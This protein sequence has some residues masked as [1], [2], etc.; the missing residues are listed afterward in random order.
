[1]D[2]EI[3][4]WLLLVMGA[5]NDK[6]WQLIENCGDVRSAAE[7]MR[8][9]GC[10][11]L[12]KEESDRARQIRMREVSSLIAECDGNGINIVT[13]DDAEY[14]EQ[15]KSIYSPPLVLFVQGS[16]VPFSEKV[17]IAVVGTRRMS[18]YGADAARRICTELAAADMAIVSG[19]AVG[20]D[21]IAHRCALERGAKTVGV[22]ACG[23]LVDY[24]TAS[25]TLKQDIIRSG[26]AVVSELLPHTGVAP[27]YFGH[28]NRIISGLASGTFIVEAPERSGCLLTAEHT[29]QQSRE[30][31]CMC[32]HDTF[33]GRFSGVIPYLRDGAIPVF[34]HTDII[35][36]LNYRINGTV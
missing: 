30:L 31:F 14:P 17:P 12:S 11:M 6:V 19:L 9:G 35:N 24:P 28:R 26:G 3:W 36:G 18:S 15:L 22:L 5:N 34:D 2:R 25:R 23:S 20:I 10:N 29:I 4:L 13:Y 27:E 16:L 32:P 7:A 21:T 1:M 8:D 33:S